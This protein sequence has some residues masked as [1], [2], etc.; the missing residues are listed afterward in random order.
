[1]ADLDMESLLGGPAGAGSATGRATG[2]FLSSAGDAAGGAGSARHTGAAGSVSAGTSIAQ[3][4]ETSQES[5]ESAIWMTDLRALRAGRGWWD[6]LLLLGFS[7]ARRE[8]AVHLRTTAA[9]RARSRRLSRVDAAGGGDGRDEDGFG[10]GMFRS[11]NELGLACVLHFLFTRW[12]PALARTLRLCF[13][14]LDV[15][16]KRQWRSEA[17]N[18]LAD[19]ELSR[20]LRSARAS[21]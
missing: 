3:A 2:G 20:P 7:S 1:M 10:P 5:D 17:A 13:P 9:A 21:N 18:V 14:P 8:Y 15:E 12:R 16:A 6:V 4:G 11:S 19:S